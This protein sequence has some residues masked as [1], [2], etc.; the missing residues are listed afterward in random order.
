MADDASAQVDELTAWAQPWNR[1]QPQKE[2]IQDSSC[3]SSYLNGIPLI[4]Q[5]AVARY[6]RTVCKHSTIWSRF[7]SDGELQHMAAGFI[8]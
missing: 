4:E 1:R 8:G 6:S 7:Y 2:F 5:S 3:S